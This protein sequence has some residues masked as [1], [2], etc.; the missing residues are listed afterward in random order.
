MRRWKWPK[1]LDRTLYLS[2]YGVLRYS[3]ESW[4]SKQTRCAACRQSSLS[5]RADE[6]EASRV[7]GG[8]AKTSKHYFIH[9]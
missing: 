5:Y 4:R 2:R 3:R 8:G 7:Q 1:T 9:K 6:E